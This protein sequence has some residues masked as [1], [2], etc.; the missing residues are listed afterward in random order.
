VTA[1]LLA[2]VLGPTGTAGAARKAENSLISFGR[3]D[4]AG[5]RTSLWVATPDGGKQRQLAEDASFSHWSPDGSRLAFDFPDGDD[6]HIATIK[7]D[8]SRQKALTDQAGIQESPKWSPDGKWIA[9]GNYD[10]DQE[11]EFSTS[12]WV[13]RADGS[14]EDY[15]IEV[16]VE[17]YPHTGNVVKVDRVGVV[18]RSPI[19]ADGERA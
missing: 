14:D 17:H 12:I 18:P 11:G 1:A 13:M 9:Y 10:P 16:R 7:P 19:E 5:G 4:F 2:L 3:S 8:G 6:V 15:F